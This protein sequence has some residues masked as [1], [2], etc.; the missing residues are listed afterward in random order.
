MYFTEQE[1]SSMVH[2][3]TIT[4]Q[5]RPSM[6]F[7]IHDHIVHITLAQKWQ[8]DGWGKKH[9]RILSGLIWAGFSCWGKHGYK[10]KLCTLRVYVTYSLHQ[11]GLVSSISWWSDTSKCHSIRLQ[12]PIF[13]TPQKVMQR[14]FLGC[15]GPHFGP[16]NT[17]HTK[18][19]QKITF[20]VLFS[21]PPQNA[22]QCTTV[23]CNV[24]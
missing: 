4:G 5:Y 16:T 1:Y 14:F 20:G 24:L 3:R 15:T 13:P 9:S 21:L 11:C 10:T 7:A 2:V 22:L 18:N 19:Y 17:N 8:K 12:T 6:Y 23:Q